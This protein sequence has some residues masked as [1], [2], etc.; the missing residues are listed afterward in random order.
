LR[1]GDDN[2]TALND[3]ISPVDRRSD[4]LCYDFLRDTTLRLGRDYLECLPVV[5]SLA[6]VVLHTHTE[7]IEAREDGLEVPRETLAFRGKLFA[8]P[9]RESQLALPGI[10]CN[11]REERLKLGSVDRYDRDR[12]FGLRL[13]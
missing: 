5:I 1:S 11:I 8:G 2:L 4:R 3:L 12:R 10:G 7:A 6:R 13:R 9:C